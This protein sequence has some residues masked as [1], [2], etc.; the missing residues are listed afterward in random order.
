MLSQLPL[1]SDYLGRILELLL[2]QFFRLEH[3]SVRV[4]LFLEH[5]L[6]ESLALL[7]LHDS[8][9][10]LFLRVSARLIVKLGR[11]CCEKRGVVFLD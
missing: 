9:Q 10:L 6:N 8:A 5:L 2:L 11:I 1:D 7:L 3:Y 4:P